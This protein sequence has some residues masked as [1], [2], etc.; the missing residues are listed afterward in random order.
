MTD[1]VIVVGAGPT[2]LALTEELA[3]NGVPVRLLERRADVPNI[4]RAFGVHARTLEL[5]NARGLD[6]EVVQRGLK[7]SSAQLN[8]GAEID[9]RPLPTPFNYMVIVPQSGTETV[10][11]KR[12]AEMGVHV[13]RGVEVLGVRQDGDG[14]EVEVRQG[15]DIH[16]IRG[17]YVVGCDGAHSKIRDEMG[18]KFVGD[19]YDIHLVLADVK[20]TNPPADTVYNALSP[21]GIQLLVP[22]GDGYYRSISFLHGAP[23][24]KPLTIDDIRQASQK[25]TGQDFGIS[26]VRWMTRFLSE[27]RQA[28][29]YRVGR[30]LL[31]GDAAHVHSPAGA[32]GMNTGIGDAMNL[33]WKLAATLK[34]TAPSWLLDTYEA[35][36]HHTG[37][38]VLKVTDRV[39][40][41]TMLKSEVAHRVI[42]LLMRRLLKID[43][44]QRGPRAFLSGIGISYAARGQHP[45]KL[46]GHRA[47][48]VTD[49]A[50][51]MHTGKFVLVDS[52]ES[53]GTRPDF[54]D[55]VVVVHRKPVEGIPPVML[56]RPD[57]YVAWA[58]DTIDEANNAT[59]DW[60]GPV[61]VQA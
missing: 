28:E 14:V 45:H 41:V 38:Q 56:I 5:L 27:R 55:R 54:G 29:H 26:E 15:S 2:G 8:L 61:E 52:T 43:A 1:P 48:F 25:I 20:L 50:Q 22:F 33:G 12:C 40:R 21:A 4:T 39:F 36:R 37:E 57:G 18:V 9:F 44:A 58:G 13:E 32:Q 53:A 60:C 7:V 35:E 3:L 19:V 42:G 6:D 59:A 31:A 30:M 23:T 24:D 51:E 34:G 10:L 11:E 16:T 47:P 17:S 49:F 46:A